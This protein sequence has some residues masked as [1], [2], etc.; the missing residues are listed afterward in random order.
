MGRMEGEVALVTGGAS[1]LGRAIV[2]R[3]VEEGAR[4]VV[5]DRSEAKLQDVK[6]SHGDAVAIHA[7]D[8]RSGPDNKAAVALA[9][10]RFP[11]SSTAPS[12]M[13]AIWDYSVTLRR[14]AGRA[15]R[16]RL[17]RIVRRQCEGLP[18]S[19]K[20]GA[21][22]AGPLRRLARLYG[23]QC[24]LR[25]GGRRRALHRVET[26]GCRIDPPARFRIRP[27]RPRQWR[28]AGAD[29]YRPARAGC[30]RPCRQGD[31]QHRSAAAVAAPGVPLGRVAGGCG[32]SPA[33]MS[34]SRRG[35]TARPQPAAS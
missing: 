32:I 25:S 29:R 13:P 28:C 18:A 4:V 3:F 7:G 22:G 26:C 15:D 11:A 19:R 9:V 21:A 27:H 24:R 10:E 1:G 17:R 14:H 2:D 8:V 16:R 23:F 6:R 5:F 34:I 33:P 31:Q 30:A 20:G 35:G 12:A